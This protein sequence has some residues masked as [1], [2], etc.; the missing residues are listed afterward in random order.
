MKVLEAIRTK[1]AVR[2]YQDK[3]LSKEIATAILDAGRR[4]QSS[5][6][7]QPWHFIAIRDKAILQSLANAGRYVAHVENAALVVAIVTPN[8]EQKLSIMFDAGQTASYM[9]LAAWELGVASGL[10]GFPDPKQARDILGF[11]PELHLRMA[12]TFG[13]ALNPP[14]PAKRGGRRSIEEIVHWDKW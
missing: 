9:Q 12:I 1:R 8:P 10:V 13:Y 5:K 11:P 3:P 6:N 14:Q 7:T 4:A 2:Q